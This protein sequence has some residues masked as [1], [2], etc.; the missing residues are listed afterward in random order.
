MSLILIF[1]S[2]ANT[3]K[4]QEDR[5]GRAVS[6]SGTNMCPPLPSQNLVAI[7][8]GK[9]AYSY[10]AR[11]RNLPSRKNEGM[12]TLQ[13]ETSFTVISLSPE[14]LGNCSSQEVGRKVF[15]ES[16]TGERAFS[17]V[18]PWLWS[19]LPREVHQAPSQDA[20]RK[21]VETEL[22]RRAC[23]AIQHCILHGGQSGLY[24]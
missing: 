17:V 4:L 1:P 6:I 21:K 5:Q 8:V 14:N 22:F 12:Y 11:V 9:Y 13:R 2:K 24:S 18:A 16:S 19:S 20:F 15:G 23:A 10:S 3:T 7:A